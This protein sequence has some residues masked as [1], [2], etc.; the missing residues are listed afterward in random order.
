MVFYVGLHQPSDLKRGY[1]TN[2]FLS[3]NRLLKRKHMHANNWILDSGAF[4]EI[5][6]HGDFRLSV[7]E[8]ARLI[9]KWSQVG[10]LQAAVSQDFLCNE[11]ML[12][13]T[14]LTVRQHQ[15]ITIDRYCQLLNQDTAGVYIMPVLQGNTPAEYVQHI[16]MYGTL[17]KPGAWTG[18][19]SVVAKSSNPKEVL[20]ILEAI[21]GA[22][23]DLKLHGFGLKHK[24]CSNP[25]ILALLFSA[26]SQA[27]SQAARREGRNQNCFTEALAYEAKIKALVPG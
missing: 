9:R 23:P 19:G 20:A 18:V 16:A 8:Y 12:A 4:T 6:K 27:W 25:A 13:K 14:G 15:Q 21:A 26:D 17:L 22:R 10:N 2:A 3:V 5:S 7:E 1:F 24:A 11:Q